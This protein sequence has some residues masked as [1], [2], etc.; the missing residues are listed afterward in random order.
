MAKSK[1]G[2]ARAALSLALALATL[3]AL[4]A[5][6][7]TAERLV[8]RVGVP[9]G[10]SA[11]ACAFLVLSETI[12]TVAQLPLSV[13]ST[14]GVEAR[15]GFNKQTPKGF[16]VDLV[17]SLVLQAALGLPIVVALLAVV[18]WGG[19]QFWLYAWLLVASVTLA[20]MTIYPTFIAPIFNKFE[21]LPEGDLRSGIEKLAKRLDFPL[22]EIFTMDASTRSAHS[23][24]YFFGLFKKRIVLYD[25]LME[26]VDNEGI[27]AILGHELGHW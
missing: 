16:V 1:L 6:W 4:P 19:E 24:A 9:G 14:F 15:F 25:T 10:D 27:V 13:Y 26:Q 11:S 5:L 21:A 22:T 8:A 7:Q 23:N 12:S 18:R 2:F 17:K 20:L 3:Y